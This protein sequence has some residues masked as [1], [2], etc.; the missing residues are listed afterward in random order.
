[1]R[2]AAIEKLKSCGT[3]WAAVEP[4]IACL[5]DDDVDVRKAATEA[6]GELNDTRAIEPLIARLA[7]DDRQTIIAA[8]GKPCASAG[9]RLVS[10]LQNKIPRIPSWL[11]PP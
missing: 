2:L 7:T 5:G 8:L 1:M 6:F 9:E 11:A 4:L 3:T 10:L